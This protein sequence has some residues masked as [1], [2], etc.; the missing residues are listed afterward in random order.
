MVELC[1]GSRS[2]SRSVVA[3]EPSITDDRT[4]LVA[5]FWLNA[6]PNEQQEFHT[7]SAPGVVE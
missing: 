1:P 5:G 2:P 6:L 7:M 3:Y 4:A